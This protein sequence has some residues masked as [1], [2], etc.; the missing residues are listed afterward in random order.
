[1][2][3]ESTRRCEIAYKMLQPKKIIRRNKPFLINFTEEELKEMRQ[4][5]NEL[6]MKVAQ[7]V[8][9]NLFNI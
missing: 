2:Y 5:V 7:Y 1:M 4:E 3:F 6:R 9:F 8:R